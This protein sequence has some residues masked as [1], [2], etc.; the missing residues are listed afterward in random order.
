MRPGMK[1]S[2]AKQQIKIFGFMNNK[3]ILWIG[4]PM[5][6][7]FMCSD[8]GNMIYFTIIVR[9]GGLANDVVL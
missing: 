1:N 2:L 9:K 6:Q 5:A 7:W 3:D 8:I 4:N